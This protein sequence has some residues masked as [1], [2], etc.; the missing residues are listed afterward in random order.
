MVCV[1]CRRVAYSAI[2]T[3][4]LP[5][6]VWYF[7][8]TAYLTEMK[9]ANCSIVS[10]FNSNEGWTY[11]F[12]VMVTDECPKISLRVLMSILAST[13]RVANVCRRTWKFRFSR[14]HA[15]RIL[16]N[17]RWTQRGSISLDDEPLRKY[18]VLPNGYIFRYSNNIC[19]TG[20]VRFA[21]LLLGDEMSICVFWDSGIRVWMRCIVWQIQRF[22][23]E[24]EILSHVNAHSSPIR[25]PVNRHKRMP[26]FRQSGWPIRYFW[27]V[28]CSDKLKTGKCFVAFYNRMSKIAYSTWIFRAFA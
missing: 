12:I 3:T 1:S 9:S 17:R 16:W 7:E 10:L 2:P 15:M 26:R 13:Q 22:L 19:E 25:I 6:I 24:R 14:P 28:N 5:W 8:T 4:K 21:E 20:I 27:S 23:S 11:R 18:P